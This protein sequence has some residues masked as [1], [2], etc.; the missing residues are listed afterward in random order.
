M[1]PAAP[2]VPVTPTIRLHDISKR[3]G[4]RW[5]LSR[6]S[7][8][9]APG[10]SVMLTGDNGAGKTTLLKVMATLWRP[11]FGKVELFGQTVKG[12][13]LEVRA[14]LGLM[15]HANHLYD[16]QTARENLRFVARMAGDGALGRIP[17]VLER[18]G[19]SQHA[20]RPVRGF[21]AGM[22]RRLIM[23]RLLL[24]QAELVLLDEPWG[25]LDAAA[26]SLMDDMIRTLKKSGTTLVIA[27]HDI[28]RAEALCDTRLRLAHGR[29]VD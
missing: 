21:S 5:V 9:V 19:L 25:A 28:E 20:D 23:A 12:S 15:T 4:N 17:D 2:D 3:I 7:Y 26:I 29:K 14:R 11:T 27:T 16:A 13:A 10:S 6:L 18:V 22:K 24:K 1:V 8:E